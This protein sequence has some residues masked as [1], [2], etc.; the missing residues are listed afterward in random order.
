MDT[1]FHC[2]VVPSGSKVST[3]VA[4][5]GE[6]KEADIISAAAAATG[7]NRNA[8]QVGLTATPRHIRVKQTED[9]ET[10]KGV[11]EDKR[12]LADNY[13]YFGEPP[14]EYSYICSAS[15]GMT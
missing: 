1:N 5:Q 2:N 8:I 3:R 14:Y 11:E 6:L 9:E 12:K 4:F 13:S 10:K 15:D 7:L